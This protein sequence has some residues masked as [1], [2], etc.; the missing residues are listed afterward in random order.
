MGEESAQGRSPKASSVRSSMMRSRSKS[1]DRRNSKPLGARLKGMM[2]GI[3]KSTKKI[4]KSSKTDLD[5]RASA[6]IQIEEE[7]FATIPI[8]KEVHTPKADPSNSKPEGLK[9]FRSL[10]LVLLLMDP[11][12]RRFELL[13]LEF[14]SEK[15]RVA[16]IIAQIPVSVTEAA[17][18]GQKY[19]YV[20]DESTAMRLPQTRLLDFCNGRQVLVAVPKGTTIKEC[21]RL[22]R[23]ILC[24]PQVVKMVRIHT[25][26]ALPG[27]ACKLR[28]LYFFR[29]SY[30]VFL[31]YF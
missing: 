6:H 13:Q 20:L 8:P 18:R 14:D 29:I 28:T 11:E 22:A 15:A 31:Y 27:I 23:P 1:R 5:S 19:E 4:D 24:D 7:H 25:P 30:V 2:K 17:I 3:R 12:S 21:V 10:Q 16:D 26:L 9:T